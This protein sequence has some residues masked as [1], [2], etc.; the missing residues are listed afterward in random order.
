[1]GDATSWQGNL[2]KGQRAVRW[3]AA[4]TATELGNLGTNASSVT[5]SSAIDINSLGATVG[6]ATKYIGGVSQGDRAVRWA[7]SNTIALE[8]TILGTDASGSSESYAHD[9]NEPGTSVGYARKYEA[10]INKG[11]R[12]VRWDSLAAR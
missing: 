5:S 2:N 7:A 4:G 8:L 12:A 1:M 3:N 9:I 11:L 6:Y 10:N